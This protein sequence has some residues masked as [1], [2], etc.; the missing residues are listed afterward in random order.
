M[1]SVV[2]LSMWGPARTGY[3]CGPKVL[4]TRQHRWDNQH[5]MLH[6]ECLLQQFGC[7]VLHIAPSSCIA[8]CCAQRIH[9]RR[10]PVQQLQCTFHRLVFQ[11]SDMIVWASHSLDVGS[12]CHIPAI[13][14]LDVHRQGHV[15]WAMTDGL[16]LNCTRCLCDWHKR[17][18]ILCWCDNFKVLWVGSLNCS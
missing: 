10:V 7:A 16:A 2:L 8:G 13:A 11:W 1:K 14:S 4:Q 17:V 12:Q 6:A 9:A 18:V 5:E 3:V 15:S